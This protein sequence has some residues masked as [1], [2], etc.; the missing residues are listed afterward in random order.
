MKRYLFSLISICFVIIFSFNAHAYT[1]TFNVEGTVVKPAPAAP[2]VYGWDNEPFTIKMTIDSNKLPY[3]EVFYDSSLPYDLAVP[4]S[5][6]SGSDYFADIAV[7]EVG[8]SDLSSD[9]QQST[10]SM[11]HFMRP[12]ME[13]HLQLTLNGPTTPSQPNPNVLD[14]Y[15]RTR[16]KFPSE[17]F[18]NLA[19]HPIAIPGDVVLADS[20]YYDGFVPRGDINVPSTNTT[21]YSLEVTS[22]SSVPEPTTMLLLGAGLVGL[23]GFGRKKFRK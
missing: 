6:K 7:L 20:F 3:R 13:D 14:W 23:A 17:Y 11:A 16:F 15:F 4:E 9:L 10:I 12:S 5:F 21:L 8:G 1:I 2:D 18:G 22:M 19:D